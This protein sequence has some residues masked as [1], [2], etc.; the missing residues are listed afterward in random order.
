VVIAP[1]VGRRAARGKHGGEFGFEVE[2][3]AQITR[4]LGLDDQM[5]RHKQGEKQQMLF[6]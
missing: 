3:F 4:G 2:A 6:H 5:G 1:V